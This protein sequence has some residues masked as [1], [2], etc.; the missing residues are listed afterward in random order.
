MKPKVKKA[1]TSEEKI[2]RLLNELHAN[3][4]KH[5]KSVDGGEEKVRLHMVACIETEDEYL[6]RFA[7][8]IVN[9]FGIMSFMDTRLRDISRNKFKS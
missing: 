6:L 8:K 2:K 7:G 4:V 9:H 3:I 1:E 5:N